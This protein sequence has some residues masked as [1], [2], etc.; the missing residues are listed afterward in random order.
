MLR[1]SFSERKASAGSIRATGRAWPCMPPPRPYG[2]RVTGW[3]R[4]C[5]DVLE[6]F[7][8]FTGSSSSSSSRSATGG[9]KS[10]GAVAR[11]SGISSSSRGGSGILGGDISGVTVEDADS[12]GADNNDIG[13][14]VSVHDTNA[15]FLLHGVCGVLAGCTSAIL[16]NPLDVAKTRIQVLSKGSAEE[17]ASAAAQGKAVGTVKRNPFAVL[18]DL[19]REEGLARAC[20]RGLGAR[21]MSMA[22]ISFLMII[23]YEHVK[24]L[25]RIEEK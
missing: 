14:R 16:T 7:V 20:T 19:V 10:P 3:K 17:S 8:P 4:L 2:G 24:R 13:E 6:E 18:Y 11:G 22:P 12:D 9:N 23:S 15:R 21:I 25:S 5:T 1:V